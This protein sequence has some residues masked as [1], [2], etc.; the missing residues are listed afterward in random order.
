[1]FKLIFAALRRFVRAIIRI[2]GAVNLRLRVARRRLTQSRAEEE[3][4]DRI[5]HPYKYRGK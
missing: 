2:P 4:I 5:R 3:R 1:M